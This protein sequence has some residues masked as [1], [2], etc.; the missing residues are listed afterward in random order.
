MFVLALSLYLCEF[1]ETYHQAGL[2]HILSD[3]KVLSSLKNARILEENITRFFG[4][5]HFPDAVCI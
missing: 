3:V 5:V 4:G 1:G 2:S